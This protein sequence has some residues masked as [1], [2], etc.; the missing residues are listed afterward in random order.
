MATSHIRLDIFHQELKDNPALSNWWQHSEVAATGPK[1][2]DFLTKFSQFSQYVGPEIVVSGAM[3]GKEP[4]V[5]IVAEA[6]KPGVTKFLEQVT[7]ELA[8]KS[9]PFVRVLDPKELAAASNS[10]PSEKFFVLVR[11][12]FIVGAPELTAL[13]DFSA[14]LDRG[15]SGFV[16][17]PFGQRIARSYEGGATTLTAVDLHKIVSQIPIANPRDQ[18]TFADTGFADVKYLVWEHKTVAG[19]SIAEAELSFTGPR[20][21]MAAWLAKPGPMGSLDF[22]SPNSIMLS[23]VLL[24]NPGQIFED[25]KAI[26]TVT[27]PNA[28]AALATFEQALKVS[29]KDDL[30]RQLGGELMVELVSVAPPKPVWRAALRVTDPSHL[31]QT[32]NGLLAATHIPAEHSDEAGVTYYS[33]QIPNPPTTRE[34]AYAFVDG[35][36]LIAS[37]HEALAEAIEL[38]KSG[39]SVGNPRNFWHRC[40]PAMKRVLLR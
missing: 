13:R 39:E 7:E 35:Y 17:T 29:L 27:N 12:D 30:L 34:I 18:K 22:A 25:V 40:R 9:K 16:S 11:P 23:S 38:H 28:F 6:R 21:G 26:A 4:S 32:L 3:Q 36:W 5:L 10:S 15:G 37:S 1:V 33:V 8:G 31:Q 20:H 2:E 24:T 14:Q 19:Q